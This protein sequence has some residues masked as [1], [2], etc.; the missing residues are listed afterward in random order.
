MIATETSILTDDWEMTLFPD[1]I[2][3]WSPELIETVYLPWEDM[4]NAVMELGISLNPDVAPTRPLVVGTYPIEG[5]RWEIQ[6]PLTVDEDL[7]VECDGEL[8]NISVLDLIRS[9]GS[10]EVDE[11]GSL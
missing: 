7:I 5:R 1:A 6:L 9:I 2:S 8:R 4:V 10:F 3:I 11:E